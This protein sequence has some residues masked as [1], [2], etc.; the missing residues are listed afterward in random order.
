MKTFWL[1]EMMKKRS[2]DGVLDW[3]ALEKDIE[4]RFRKEGREWLILVS[5]FL[6]GI[7]FC[8]VLLGFPTVSGS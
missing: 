5:C 6:G 2:R 8:Y 7:W 3:V 1:G 4:E